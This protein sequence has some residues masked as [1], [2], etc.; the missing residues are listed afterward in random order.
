MTSYPVKRFEEFI[1]R[2]ASGQIVMI[3]YDIGR[4]RKYVELNPF[5]INEIDLRSMAE[6]LEYQ[7][8]KFERLRFSVDG[9]EQIFKQGAS[10]KTIN[11]Y[12]KEQPREDY[13]EAL[14]SV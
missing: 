1:D 9:G 6:F 11:E 5:E 13:D 2:L 14:G 8:D 10:I 3:D 12:W 7:A 4:N